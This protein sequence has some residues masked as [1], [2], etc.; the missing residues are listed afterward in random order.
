MSDDIQNDE[1]PIWGIHAIAL[2]INRT[3]RATHHLLINGKLP[4]KKVGAMWVGATRPTNVEARA[5][6]DQET[7]HACR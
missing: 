1:A 3:A 7:A 6:E 5:A 4:A 2:E